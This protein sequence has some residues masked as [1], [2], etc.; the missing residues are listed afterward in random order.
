MGV[1]LFSCR[2]LDLRAYDSTLLALLTFTA[3]CR[4]SPSIRADYIH[5]G[6]PLTAYLRELKS[7]HLD[8]HYKDPNLGYGITSKFWDL[9]F[10]TQ[11]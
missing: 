3:I 1:P 2:F 8:H 5:H 4:P 10:H 7:Y 11:L 9:V 6:R